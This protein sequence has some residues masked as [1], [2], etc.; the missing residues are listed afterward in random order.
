MEDVDKAEFLKGMTTYHA[1]PA[2]FPGSV[3][4]WTDDTCHLLEVI[5][6]KGYK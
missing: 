2:L 4:Q 1:K 5:S 3:T 6:G